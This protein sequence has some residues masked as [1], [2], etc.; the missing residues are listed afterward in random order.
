MRDRIKFSDFLKCVGLY[1]PL[2]IDL[3]GY[4]DDLE[5]KEG[6]YRPLSSSIPRVLSSI[7]CITKKK[8]IYY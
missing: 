2:K 5:I 3:M 8:Y 6:A 4:D 1:T 7:D